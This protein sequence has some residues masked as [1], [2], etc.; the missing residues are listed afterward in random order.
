MDY[1]S[2]FRVIRDIF[3]L[4]SI[5]MYRSST[6]LCPKKDPKKSSTDGWH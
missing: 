5:E 3:F 1:G 4:D 2:E 6:G